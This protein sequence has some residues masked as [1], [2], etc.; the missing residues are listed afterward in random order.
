MTRG[1]LFSKTKTHGIKRVGIR[2]IYLLDALW[3]RL[4]LDDDA[5][6]TKEWRF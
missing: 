3:A 2:E 5:E 4:L 1:F 6:V